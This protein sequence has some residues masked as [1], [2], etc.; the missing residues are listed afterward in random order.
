MR[1]GIERGLENDILDFSKQP[2][3]I[4]LAARGR[5]DSFQTWFQRIFNF[6]YLDVTDASDRDV[7]ECLTDNFPYDSP[8]NLDKDCVEI[9]GQLHVN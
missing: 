7:R 5:V 9:K 1:S 6:W 4:T 2:G 8:G 3:V